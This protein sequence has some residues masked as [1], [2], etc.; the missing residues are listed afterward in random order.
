MDMVRLRNGTDVAIRPIRPDDGPRLQE[1]Y[2]QLSVESRYQ[3]FLALKS[4]LSDD[5]LH[6]L[7][8]VDGFEH[9]ALVATPID[10]PD[11]IIAVGRFVRLR[12]DPQRAEFAIVVGDQ[13]HRQGLGSELLARLRDRARRRG[14]ER[15]TATVLADNIAAHRLLRGLNGQLARSDRSGPFDEIELDLA[16]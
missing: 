1:S 3:R 11:T 12:D 13:F 2:E 14:I 5:D 16:A 7:V 10:N 15:F 9:V 6:Y 4:H 8:E